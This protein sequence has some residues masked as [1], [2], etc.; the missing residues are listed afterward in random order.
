[1]RTAIQLS[2]IAT[3]LFITVLS[4]PAALDPNLILYFT[5]DEQ[6]DGRVIEDMTGGGNDGKLR[7]GAK[8]TNE[9]VE[10][11]KGA[12]ALKIS[13]NISAQF[14][15]EPFDRMN[16]YQDHTVAFWI[17]FFEG[18]HQGEAR[19][20]FKKNA[21]EAQVLN[22]GFPKSPSVQISG[23]SF[24][25]FYEV[26]EQGGIDG[27]GPDG[28]G[29]E[30]E[31]ERWYHIAG[32]KKGVDLIIYIDG[33]EEGRFDV[34]KKFPQGEGRLR[35]GG[36]RTRAAYFAMD[37]LALFDRVL[38]EKEVELME[39]GVFLSIEPQDKLTTTWGRL[40]TGH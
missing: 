8:L 32:V 33:E 15:V 12:G 6:L 20:I 11:Y 5:F 7:L 36:T 28:E 29:S 30:F 1:M 10:V 37:E 40:K 2:L 22:A 24:A 26:G 16:Q 31:V 39:K 38:T 34:P 9:P 19:S 3:F 25:L 4:A 21:D 13:G 23:N 27:L 35:I 18:F 14:R 17:Y